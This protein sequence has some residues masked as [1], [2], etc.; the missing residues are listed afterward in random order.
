M[1]LKIL[2]AAARRDRHD[3]I[4]MTQPFT[5]GRRALLRGLGAALVATACGAHKQPPV[6]P[7]A[8][9]F[10][11][12]RHGRIAYRERGRGEVAVFLHG[13]PLSS[14][15]WRDAIA[16][17]A[18]LRRCLAPDFLALGDTE[19]ADGQGVAPHDQADMIV[20]FLDALG[21]GRFDLVASDS[22]GAVAQLLAARCPDRIRSVLLTNCD[23]E[24]DSPPAALRP[25][26]ELARRG[27][28][29]DAWL[30]RWQ[31]DHALARSPEGIGG[32]CYADPAHPTDAAIAAYF[33]PLLA[34]PRRKALVHA[35]A[36]G[37]EKNP[38]TGIEYALGCLKAP[39]RVVWG[40]AD[41]IFSS[42]SPAYLAR[43]VGNSRGVRTLAGSKLFWPEERPDVIAEEARALWTAA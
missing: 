38:L 21:V 34:S 32:M 26:I 8:Q 41:S 10:V 16:Q 36:L 31:R 37:L 2:T 18:P 28:F 6:S 24:P 15:Q 23:T 4:T 11:A 20:A 9:R 42:D 33:T 7:A 13:F 25:V 43:T 40:L 22:G 19:V 35:Y 39:V 12:T 29:A 1:S 27:A 5:I 17:L 30:G 3:A 14:F